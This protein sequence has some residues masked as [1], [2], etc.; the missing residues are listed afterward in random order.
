MW[1]VVVTGG[2]GSGKTAVT[3]MLAQLGAVRFDADQVVR[4]LLQESAVLAQLAQRWGRELLQLEVADLR[5]VLAGKLFQSAADRQY[6]ERLLHPLVSQRLVKMQH[7][8]Q[9]QHQPQL[10]QPLPAASPC[11]GYLAAEIPL[12]YQMEHPPRVDRV[13]A[14]ICSNPTLR[15]TRLLAARPYLTQQQIQQFQAAQLPDALY[16]AQA[17]DLIDN[18]GTIIQLQQRVTDLHVQY[19]Q[20]ALVAS[21]HQTNFLDK[22]SQNNAN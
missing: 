21:G 13:L 22:T 10:L 18:N 14:V 11:G 3:K 17:D 9:L 12:Y 15:N 4:E 7:Q 2:I 6:L 5:R 1:T 19:L 8:H 20:L 16:A